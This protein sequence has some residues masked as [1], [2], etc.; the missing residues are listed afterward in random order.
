MKLAREADKSGYLRF[1]LVG[2]ASLFTGFAAWWC[3]VSFVRPGTISVPQLALLVTALSVGVVV[4]TGALW[5]GG[6]AP[7]RRSV[8]ITT[9]GALVCLV[10]FSSI[11]SEEGW[12]SVVPS[13]VIFGPPIVAWALMWRLGG[14][15]IATTS[16]RRGF[17]GP[18]RSTD[19]PSHRQ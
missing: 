12:L 11:T 9:G 7:A 6:T 17:R 16:V 4:L 19:S 3:A 13:M 10:L 2:L 1:G 18:K 14:K 15:Y 5:A 8:S